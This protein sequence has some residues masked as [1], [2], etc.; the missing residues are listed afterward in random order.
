MN[1]EIAYLRESWKKAEQ[2]DDSLNNKMKQMKNQ[3]RISSMA[4]KKTFLSK[5]T[6]KTIFVLVYLFILRERA[7]R[8]GGENE[9]GRERIPSRLH[10]SVQSLMRGLNPRTVRS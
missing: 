5:A 9:R 7:S 2:T 4:L 6:T 1:R 8:G 3:M 10:T